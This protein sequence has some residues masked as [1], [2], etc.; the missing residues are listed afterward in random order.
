MLS[1]WKCC[2]FNYI[3]RLE[4]LSFLNARLSGLAMASFMPTDGEVLKLLFPMLTVYL[5]ILLL[6]T[7]M[8]SAFHFLIHLGVQKTE[9]SWM[10]LKSVSIKLVVWIRPGVESPC[11]I[12]GKDFCDHLFPSVVFPIVVEF[13]LFECQLFEMRAFRV[14]FVRICSSK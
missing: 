6:S 11:F 3:S 5:I 1:L 9:N 13:M 12:S 14:I 4:L 10:K 7:M 8:V 2:F